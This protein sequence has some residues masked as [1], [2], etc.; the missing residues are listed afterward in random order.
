MSAAN[1]PD[2]E[3]ERLLDDIRDAKHRL[4]ELLV[5]RETQ[6]RMAARL[7]AVAA[8]R[9]SWRP[10]RFQPSAEWLA[11][12]HWQAAAPPT[13][14]AVLRL[15]SPEVRRQLVAQARACVERKAPFD[16]T[17]AAR[18]F[19]GKAVC[20]RLIGEPEVDEDGLATGLHGACQD[21]SD[22]VAREREASLL[23][24]RLTTTVESITDG[25]LSLGRDWR[26]TFVNRA[27]ENI[28]RCRREDLLGRVVWDVFPSAAGGVFLAEAELA[29]A[30]NRARTFRG[31][32]EAPGV[33]LELRA[34][35][36][37]AGLA[38][39]FADVTRQQE[40][41]D[42]LERNR[43]ELELQV[44][45]R[46]RELRLINEEL[47]AFTVAVAHDLRAPLAAIDGFSRVLRERVGQADPKARHYAERIGAG[48]ERMEAMIAALLELAR[49]GQAP[50]ERVALDLGAM[51]AEVVEA[52]RTAE[53]SRNVSVDIGPDLRATGDPRLLRNVLENLIG[54]AWKFTAQVEA[55]RIRVGREAS[56][57]F[58]VADNGAGFD[59]AHAE[60]LFV[61]F[62]RL[63]EHA[64][65][66]GTGIGLAAVRRVIQRHGGEIRA[67]SGPLGGAV[68]H[69]TLPPR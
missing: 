47:S 27:A 67:S 26:V 14:T 8:W 4:R 57:A 17:V 51:A 3:V 7:A 40:L 45:R 53:P 31:Y 41:Q 9:V 46:T 33:W 1:R 69:F 19:R 15:V 25:L 28:L 2:A 36:S 68:F 20:L 34:F 24:Q 65:F 38:V 37:D 61:P 18:T 12:L 44:A 54:N 55:A 66:P 49:M 5:D 39:Y 43:R 62:Q 6:L 32:W 50:M 58:Y 35:P 23:A 63:H 30:T 59:T 48:V 60:K 42:E 56:G 64:E 16:L 10:A 13:L 52:L 22:Q 29:L 21:T 11:L